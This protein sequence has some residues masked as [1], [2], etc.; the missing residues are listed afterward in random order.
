MR[1]R[2]TDV[3]PLLVAAGP[4]PRTGADPAEIEAQRVQTAGRDGAGERGN[5]GI[6]HRAAVRGER[7]RDHDDASWVEI[8]DAQ[9]AFEP[10]RHAHGLFA[11]GPSLAAGTRRR[12]AL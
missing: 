8:G 9:R 11:H 7:V 12:G 5:E 4:G 2:V 3:T 1:D 6:P 10:V